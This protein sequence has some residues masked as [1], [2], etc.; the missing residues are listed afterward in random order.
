MLLRQKKALINLR[1]VLEEAR[2]A[3]NNA[4][5]QAE[6]SQAQAKLV[7]AT[8]K[9]QN[10]IR[11]EKE[12]PA[13]DTTNG[14]STVGVKATNTARKQQIRIQSQTQVLEMNVMEKHWIK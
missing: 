12:A 7:T 14:K 2:T 11:R 6:L 8:T 13:V 5:T 9:L 10:K 1:T 4:K 3:L